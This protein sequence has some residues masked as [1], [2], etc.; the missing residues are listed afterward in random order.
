MTPPP[1]HRRRENRFLRLFVYG[2]LK[3][4]CENH[5]AFCAGSL[6]AENATVR[7][8]LYEHSTG[9]PILYIPPQD[10]MAFGTI[11]PL[12]DTAIQSAHDDSL[13]NSAPWGH[14]KAAKEAEGK[15]WRLI[16]G[17]L[18]T[19][20]DPQWRLPAIDELED[21][22]PG[23]LGIYSRVLVPVFRAQ[24]SAVAA[25]TYVSATATDQLKPIDKDHWPCE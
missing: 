16:R 2:T 19:F 1:S 25:W 15:K 13:D 17:E 3:R 11:N 21:F 22:S 6:T 4:G 8:R 23:Q 12:A 5:D 24:Q 7:G 20:D 18:F 9:F 10:V 14:D